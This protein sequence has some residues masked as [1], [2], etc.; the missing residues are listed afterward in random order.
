MEHS[1]G[2]YWMFKGACRFDDLAHRTILLLKRLQV[3]N[4]LPFL[5]NSRIIHLGFEP[6]GQGAAA[7]YHCLGGS[8]GAIEW[9]ESRGD[10][11]CEP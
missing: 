8:M 10:C 6:L 3:N 5:K 2:G 9:R 7:E 4:L 11:L 1:E